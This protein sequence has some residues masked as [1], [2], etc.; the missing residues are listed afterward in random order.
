MNKINDILI[1]QTNSNQHF[2]S[3]SSIVDQCLSSPS[4]SKDDD[5]RR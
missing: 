1:N 2:G 5:E 3:S 4:A